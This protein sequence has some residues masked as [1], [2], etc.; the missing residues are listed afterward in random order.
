VLLGSYEQYVLKYSLKMLQNQKVLK[1]LPTSFELV[2]LILLDIMIVLL[3]NSH[4]LLTY[5]GLQSSNAV[6]QEGAG[7]AV[8][9][10][11]AHLDSLSLTDQVVT[12]MIWAG[13][14]IFCYSVVQSIAKVYHEVE[15]DR[16]LSSSHYVHPATFTKAKF[17][18]QVIIDFAVLMLT[19]LVVALMVYILLAYVLPVTLAYCRAF[20]AGVSL[21]SIVDIVI[22]LALMYVWLLFLN[23]CLRI[24]VHHRQLTT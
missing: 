22:G 13:V 4:A 1:V 12:F 3:G 5:F 6:L 18:K 9:R 23:I 7:A 21:I 14:G 20:M 8:T 10:S 2:A 15:F 11:L 19:V 24:V 17:W 16:E